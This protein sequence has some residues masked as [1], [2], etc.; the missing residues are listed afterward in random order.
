MDVLEPIISR[1]SATKGVHLDVLSDELHPQLMEAAEIAESL[2]F[3]NTVY[4]DELRWWTSPFEHSEGIPYSAL[5]SEAESDRVGIG[6]EFPMF[7]RPERRTEIPEDHAQVVLLSTDSDDRADVLACG[8]ALSSMLL[9][10]TVAG[11]ATCPATHAT[12]VQVARELIHSIM[13]RDA[14]AQVLTASASCPP[15]KGFLRRHRDGSC[16]R[17]YGFMNE[18][19]CSAT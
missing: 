1:T 11:L 5:V 7:R 15:R 16:L 8:E 9:E 12:E 13:D 17:Y 4:H 18:R 10:C 2:R 14:M 6:R 19:D 3:D